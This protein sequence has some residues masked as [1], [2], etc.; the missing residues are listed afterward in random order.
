[1]A[2]AGKACCQSD[3]AK[4]PM[5]LGNLAA[6]EI[7]TQSTDVLTNSRLIEP[8]KLGGHERW[9]KRIPIVTCADNL[10]RFAGM[11][12]RLWFAFQPL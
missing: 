9:R 4:W 10:D 11:Q 1:M 12:F 6:G 7:N 3:L 5:G 8:A 2:L